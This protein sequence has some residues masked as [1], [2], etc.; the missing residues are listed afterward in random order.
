MIFSSSL[1]AFVLAAIYAPSAL[2]HGYLA[3]ISVDGKTFEGG[4]PGIGGNDPN[5]IRLINDITPV[6]GANNPDLVCGKGAK[7]A[8]LSAEAKPGSEIGF[9]WKNGENGPV[10]FFAVHAFRL[11]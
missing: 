10:C 3:Q 1:L 7:S 9:L 11:K 8:G 5:P 4:V 6:K 2:G